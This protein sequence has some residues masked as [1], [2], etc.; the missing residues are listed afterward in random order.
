M[1][2]LREIKVITPRGEALF[3]IP[4]NEDIFI[5]MKSSIGEEEERTLR[6]K[7]GKIIFMKEGEL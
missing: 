3:M 6:V 7:D 4:N 1:K 5:T 2:D